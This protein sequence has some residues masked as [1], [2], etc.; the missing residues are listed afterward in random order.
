MGFSTE[1][2]VKDRMTRSVMMA[3]L[4]IWCNTYPLL[5]SRSERSFTKAAR[6]LTECSP[7]SST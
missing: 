6:L 1:P 3:V 5:E 7:I 4:G 2:Y